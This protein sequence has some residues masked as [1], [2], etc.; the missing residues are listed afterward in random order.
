MK[1]MEIVCIS[2]SRQFRMFIR[3]LSQLDAPITREPSQKTRHP[4]PGLVGRIF[5]PGEIGVKIVNALSGRRLVARTS[6]HRRAEICPMP[7]V[8]TFGRLYRE[9]LA[10]RSGNTAPMS[11]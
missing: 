6:N 11:P 7:S 1:V 9:A 2:V 8:R 10:D 4:E 3:Q 5:I